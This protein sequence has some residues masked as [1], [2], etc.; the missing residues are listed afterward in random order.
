MAERVFTIKRWKQIKRDIYGDNFAQQDLIHDEKG[1]ADNG[2]L[3]DELRQRLGLGNS[4]EIPQTGL[5][6]V[7]DGNTNN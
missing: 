4:E 1:L 7:I 3:S 5:E 2:M 6:R